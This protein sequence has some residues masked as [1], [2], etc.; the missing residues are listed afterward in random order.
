MPDD[1]FQQGVAFFNSGEFFQAHE[2]W[3]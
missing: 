1:K 3:E 2:A